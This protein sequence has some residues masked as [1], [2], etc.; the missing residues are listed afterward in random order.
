MG[1]VHLR[2][3]IKIEDAL[4][5]FVIR[6]NRSSQYI[7]YNLYFYF[8]RLS[9][10]RTSERLSGVIK[11]NHVSIWNGIQKYNPKKITAYRNKI[12]GNI[13]GETVIKVG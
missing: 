8:S 9:L 1:S 3:I 5:L 2:K 12:A 6:R 7:G 4:Y 10:R 11:K 13:M